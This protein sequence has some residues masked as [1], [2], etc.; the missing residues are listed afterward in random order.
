MLYIR[1]VSNTTTVSRVTTAYLEE[2]RVHILQDK[3]I[4]DDVTIFRIHGP[5]LFGATDKLQRVSD[6]IDALPPVVI[7]R[8]RNMTAI[9]ATGLRALEDIALRIQES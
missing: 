8:L 3:H 5:F 7:F 9:D 1:R 4:P 2:G 6:K